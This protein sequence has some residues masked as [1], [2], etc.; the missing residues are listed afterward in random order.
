MPTSRYIPAFAA[1]AVVAGAACAVALAAAD[2]SG[3]RSATPTCRSGGTVAANSQARIFKVFPTGYRDTYEAYGCYRG[4]RI[5]FLGDYNVTRDCGARAF[6]LA[7]RFTA[8]DNTYCDRGED[9]GY[10]NVVDLR[11]G[12]SRASLGGLRSPVKDLELRSNG[13]VAWIRLGNPPNLEVRKLDSTGE[14]VLDSSRDIAPRSL[15]LSGG[16]V[17]WTKN[18]VPY[19]A[20]LK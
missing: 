3:S 9:P 10:V 19:S 20:E 6:R 13:S 12:R 2:A 17:Y 18:G 1:A 5:R 8:F 15:A 16:R 7:G 14:A 4:G 11:S